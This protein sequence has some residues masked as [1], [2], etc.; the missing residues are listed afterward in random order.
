MIVVHFQMY[1]FKQSKP[2]KQR[3]S[4]IFQSESYFLGLL[5]RKTLPLCLDEWRKLN[6]IARIGSLKWISAW[7]RA[8][9]DSVVVTRFDVLLILAKVEAQ[10]RT[11]FFPFLPGWLKQRV[12]WYFNLK[13]CWLW[14]PTRRDWSL[15]WDL[16]S[17]GLQTELFWHLSIL[18]TCSSLLASLLFFFLCKKKKWMKRFEVF[19]CS[20]Y[21]RVAACARTHTCTRKHWNFVV[22]YF[23]LQ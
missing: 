1:W 7:H 20:K 5:S 3:A 16:H 8:N 23:A 14:R 17:R 9:L 22:C 2:G 11:L 18:Q 13:V 21:A 12:I 4:L 19:A 15:R 6:K 10:F